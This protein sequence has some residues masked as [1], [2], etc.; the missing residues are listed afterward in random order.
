LATWGKPNSC[1]LS[2]FGRDHRDRPRIS[3]ARAK[4]SGFPP[5]GWA[6]APQKSPRRAGQRPPDAR[7]FGF[8]AVDV[9]GP[10]CL[11]PP[12]PVE[13]LCP[14]KARV[15]DPQSP[16]SAGLGHRS[17]GV[18]FFRGPPPRPPPREVV[19]TVGFSVNCFPPQPSPTALGS[20]GRPSNQVGAAAPPVQNSTCP[21]HNYGNTETV[22]LKPVAGNRP[23]PSSTPFLGQI[24]T[25]SFVLRMGSGWPAPKAGRKP[26]RC[27]PNWP[28]SVSL[29]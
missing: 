17:Q 22:F 13:A 11:S 28:G 20:P 25:Q 7:G 9:A 12:L 1:P 5:F 2:G 23:V 10:G 18:C 4:Q 3:G 14:Q 26:A 21:P 19:G 6:K 27:P 15:L 16:L 24:C 29:I 8:W